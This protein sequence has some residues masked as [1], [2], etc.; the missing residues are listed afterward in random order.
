[1]FMLRLDYPHIVLIVPLCLYI[2]IWVNYNDLT[3][4]SLESW[5]INNGNHPKWP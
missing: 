3:A 2:H 4:T 5:L 1:M